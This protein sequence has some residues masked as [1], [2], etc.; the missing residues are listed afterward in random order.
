MFT[1]RDYRYLRYD[2]IS[3]QHRSPTGTAHNMLF[4]DNKKAPDAVDKKEPLLAPAP[5]PASP[6]KIPLAKRGASWR[7]PMELLVEKGIPPKIAQR[8]A[9]LLLVIFGCAIVVVIGWVIKMQKELK[10]EEEAEA[11]KIHEPVHGG[12]KEE[13][14]P[15]VYLDIQCV[16]VSCLVL[17]VL[18]VCF[19]RAKHMLEHNVPVLMQHVL[20]AMFGELTVLGFIA[21]IAFCSVK[22][23]L[24]AEI[25]MLVYGEDEKLVELFEGVHFLL[26]FVMVIF[27]VEAC[28]L[29]VAT[30]RAEEIWREAEAD[31]QKT[32]SAERSLRHY[33]ETH[34][35]CRGFAWPTFAYYRLLGEKQRLR[36]LLLRERFIEQGK[37][38]MG[39]DKLP[40]DFDFANYL[41]RRACDEVAHLLHVDELTWG[42][43]VVFLGISLELPLVGQL[44]FPAQH[45]HPTHFSG[46]WLALLGGAYYLASIGLQV[47]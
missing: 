37:N 8:V 16:F 45:G 10:E 18:T 4:F 15:S 23:G 3:R 33:A 35:Q 30:L 9:D 32:G 22:A 13:E 43:V 26:F 14:E 5:E 17:V 31:T 28:R 2:R 24:L 1:I 29:I 11:S 27:L 46:W 42:A 7:Q 38:N 39:I 40:T 36:F 19:E 44:L 34:R 20:Q 41:R 21:L 47:V 25:S 12:V 6:P